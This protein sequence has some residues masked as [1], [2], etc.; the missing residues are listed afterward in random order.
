MCPLGVI[1]GTQEVVDSDHSRSIFSLP[2]GKYASS[3]EVRSREVGR[4]DRF[5]PTVIDDG[6]FQLYMQL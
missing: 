4:I 1:P 5:R 2:S 6:V 3:L